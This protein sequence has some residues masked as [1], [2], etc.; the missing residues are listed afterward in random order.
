MKI[1]GLLAL[2]G[3]AIVPFLSSSSS[4][5]PVEGA[6]KAKIPGKLDYNRE[7]VE[8]IDIEKKENVVKEYTEE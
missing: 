2:L 1:L 5:A 6:K 3:I 8:N 4:K 7:N